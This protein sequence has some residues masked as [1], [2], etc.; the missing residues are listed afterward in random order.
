MQTKLNELGN[1]KK[2]PIAIMERDGNVLMGHRHYKQNEWKE[3]SVWTVPGGR[4][5]Q[6]ETLEQALRREVLE[7]V[8]ITKF[9]IVDYIGEVPGAKEGDIVPIFYCTT[10]EDYTLMEPNNF[11]EWRWVPKDLYMAGEY[12][13]FNSMAR[14]ITVGYLS[15]QG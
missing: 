5:E 1:E 14:K 12:L 13:G 6:G 4:C 11:S 2:C 7:E 15:K 3:I 8:G 9:E 10:V